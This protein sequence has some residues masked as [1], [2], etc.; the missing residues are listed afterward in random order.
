VLV[1]DEAIFAHD[2]VANTK[3]RFPVGVPVDVPYA[4]S[5]HRVTVYGVLAEDR[6]CLL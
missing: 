4:G 3:C 1:Q 6:R 5:N 2:T